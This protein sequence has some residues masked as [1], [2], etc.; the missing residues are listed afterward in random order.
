MI[1]DALTD[2]AAADACGTRFLGIRATDGTNPF[3]AGTR[4]EDD[5]TGALAAFDDLLT[6]G[7]GD[8]R[9]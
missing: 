2:L 3:S 8:R 9:S 4:V 1:G 6:D 7:A 5:L